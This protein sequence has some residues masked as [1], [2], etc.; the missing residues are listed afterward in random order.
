MSNGL[1]K[2][3][4]SVHLAEH[5]LLPSE[6]NHFGMCAKMFEAP[7]E[8]D[9]NIENTYNSDKSTMVVEDNLM[10]N[11]SECLLMLE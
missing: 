3:K 10:N 1:E 5:D 2:K 8:N 6:L 11:S 4:K 9:Y 7:Y